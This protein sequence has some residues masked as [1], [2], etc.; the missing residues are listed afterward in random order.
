MTHLNLPSSSSPKP[1]RSESPSPQPRQRE[2]GSAGPSPRETAGATVPFSLASSSN[3][4]A[5]GATVITHFEK[6]S[7]SA[8]E[9]PPIKELVNKLN[10]ETR[11]HKDVIFELRTAK[12]YFATKLERSK[13]TEIKDREKT[14]DLITPILNSENARNPG[15]NAVACTDKNEMMTV[16]RDA[17]NLTQG[18]EGHIRFL[19]GDVHKL[20]VDA[21]KHRDGGFTL[22]SVDSLPH[23]QIGTEF[24]TLQKMNPD[25]IKGNLHLPTFNQVHNEGCHIFAVHTLNALHDYQP[26]IQ[27]LHKQIHDAAKGWPA[28]NLT[29]P[30][31]EKSEDTYIREPKEGALGVL[32]GK[33]FKHIQVQKPLEKRTV[34]DTAEEM[35]PAFKD[36]PVNKKGQTLRQRFE[37]LNP[38]KRPEEF[39]RFDRTSSVDKKRL[40]LIDRAIA[41]Y[42]GRA[43]EDARARRKAHGL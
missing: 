30:R 39:S 13:Q 37:S 20:A 21:F 4:T 8:P 38:S 23:R 9:L 31:W 15:L 29:D 24:G 12:G 16:L 5:S 22:I 43:R 40:V 35:N 34:L 6:R 18:Q 14:N 27:N 42:L 3:T 26:Y 11:P 33:F 25:L 28:P 2:A 7:G 17:S 41:Y 1:Y 32:P 36:Q 10:A 19:F